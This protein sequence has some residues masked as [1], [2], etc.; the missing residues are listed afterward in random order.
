MGDILD[1][2][3]DTKKL[4]E[5]FMNNKHKRVKLLLG[6]H[7]E[8]NLVGNFKYA[9]Q[10][11]IKSFG[12]PEKKGEVF[13]ERDTYGSFLV[14]RN[15]VE[16][17]GDV[18]FVHGGI[19]HDVLTEFDT[20]EEMNR[21]SRDNPVDRN[22]LWS[23]E[24]PLWFNKYSRED[25]RYICDELGH[26]LKKLDAKFMVM[27]HFEFKEIKTRCKGQAVLIDTGI[28]KS[29]NGIKSALEIL[30][31]EGQTYSIKALYEDREAVLFN[32]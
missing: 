19:S 11:D 1:K 14:K 6:N 25:E 20:V 4:L 9:T 29:I 15:I 7:E 24:G 8:L 27:G 2:G 5:Y 18:I 17:I 3:D 23:R 31:D 26:V 16:K 13:K 10:N 22:I 28:S 21:S 32:L 12:G 30:Q